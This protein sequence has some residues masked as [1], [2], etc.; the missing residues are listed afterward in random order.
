MRKGRSDDVEVISIRVQ[1]ST[2]QQFDRLA[3]MERRSRAGMIQVT[4]EHS[5]NAI[6]IVTRN[7]EW[8]VRTMDEFEKK[9]PA[10]PQLEYRR[11]QLHTTKALLTTLFGERIKDGI[12]QEIRKKTGLPIPHIV[13]VDPDGNRYG[14]DTDAG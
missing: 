5:V 1:K 11:G 13:P 12:L 10:S 2:L 6:T 14:I 7:L 3:R 8:L 9:Y 4:M